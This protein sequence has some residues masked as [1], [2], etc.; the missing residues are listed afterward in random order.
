MY[1]PLQDQKMQTEVTPSANNFYHL[2][3]LNLQHPWMR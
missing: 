2:S 3:A 1:K